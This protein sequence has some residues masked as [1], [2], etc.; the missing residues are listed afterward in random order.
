MEQDPFGVESLQC[1][2]EEQSWLA[3]LKD[4]NALARQSR[5]W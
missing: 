1:N 3:Q 4:V 5:V 2:G